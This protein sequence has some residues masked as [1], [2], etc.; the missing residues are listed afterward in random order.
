MPETRQREITAL[1]EAMVELKLTQSC[2][3]TRSEEDR[4][5]LDSGVIEVVP[6]WRF[7]LNLP[8]GI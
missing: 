1:G 5:E 6:A 4:I 8:D 3:V 7:L 2:I